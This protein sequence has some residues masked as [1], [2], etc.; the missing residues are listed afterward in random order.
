MNYLAK[1]KEKIG[2][3]TAKATAETKELSGPD[4]PF[5]GFVGPEGEHT[6]GFEMQ[7][8]ILNKPKITNTTIPDKTDERVSFRGGEATLATFAAEIKP[9][10]QRP[11]FTATVA[12]VA[13]VASYRYA[14]AKF[15][16]TRAR[17]VTRFRHDQACWAAEM[18][19]TEWE[20]M[21]AEFSWPVADIFDPR[22]LAWWLQTEIVTALGPEHAV[23]EA[24]RVYDRVTHMDWANAYGVQ[25]NG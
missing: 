4:A 23:T 8:M 6:T 17:C 19:L 9:A 5:V 13:T 25:G 2:K 18:F 10:L 14:L 20:A 3:E 12:P 24:G 1:L 7:P 16:E 21:A 22:G 15:K 11:E